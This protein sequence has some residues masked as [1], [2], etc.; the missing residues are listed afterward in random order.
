MKRRH[1]LAAGTAALAAPALA[2]AQGAETRQVRI[3]IQPGMSMM[4]LVV[5]RDRGMVGVLRHGRAGGGLGENAQAAHDRS[6]LR[7]SSQPSRNSIASRWRR[8]SAT[9]RPQA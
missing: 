8:A 6:L 2:R 3:S 1:F 7:S 4:P 9:S 5:A